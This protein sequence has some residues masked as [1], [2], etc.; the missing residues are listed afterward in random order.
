MKA[1]KKVN[2]NGQHVKLVKLLGEFVW[3]AHKDEDE[4]FLVLHGQIVIQ[5]RNRQVRVREGEFCIVPRGTQHRTV[6][7]EEAHVL[8]FEPI[9]TVIPNLA[10]SRGGKTQA[11][12]KK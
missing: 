11:K 1:T 7:R 2:L 4:L 6:A 9:S 3:H 12:K 8:L 10:P 5:F